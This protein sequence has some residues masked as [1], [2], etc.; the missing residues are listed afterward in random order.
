MTYL[1]N[2]AY[3]AKAALPLVIESLRDPSPTVRAGAARFQENLGQHA[4][5]E[6]P[7][8]RSAM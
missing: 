5:E 6:L 1:E 3:K 2:H 4:R 8:V 7:T